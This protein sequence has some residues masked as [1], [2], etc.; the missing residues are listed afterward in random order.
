MQCPNASCVMCSSET[1]IKAVECSEHKENN[2]ESM[3]QPGLGACGASLSSPG[4]IDLSDL[5]GEGNR[6]M[7]NV[8]QA[9]RPARH[10]AKPHR[11][12]AGVFHRTMY[13]QTITPTFLMAKLGAAGAKQTHS[14][15]R[16]GEG[17]FENCTLA[18]LVTC[19]HVIID[20]PDPALPYER[21]IGC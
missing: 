16:Q 19:F 3:R 20:R 9:F 5:I 11:C 6:Q 2:N 21:Q 4:R 13:V 7:M 17:W 14:Q 10:Q 8:R 12:K 1:S 18:M 15:N